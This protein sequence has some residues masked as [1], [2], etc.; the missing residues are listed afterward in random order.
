LCNYIRIAV[1]TGIWVNKI[2]HK[3][4]F[5]KFLK[6]PGVEQVYNFVSGKRK[7]ANMF[8]QIADG[9]HAFESIIIYILLN[10]L[11]LINL[12]LLIIRWILRVKRRYINGRNLVPTCI[13]FKHLS[14]SLLLFMLLVQVENLL[15]HLHIFQVF[16]PDFLYLVFNLFAYFRVGKI[17]LL[18]IGFFCWTTHL[19]IQISKSIFIFRHLIIY[20]YRNKKQLSAK[21]FNHSFILQW[22]VSTVEGDVVI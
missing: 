19:I 10:G 18:I 16:L 11:L 17:Y 5:D 2:A 21:Y 6:S 15:F 4:S 14:F 3:T 12:P 9:R 20:C 8:S 7:R 22:K 13:F 1:W